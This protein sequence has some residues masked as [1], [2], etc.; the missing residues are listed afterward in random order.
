MSYG[1]GAHYIFYYLFEPQGFLASF[2][3]KVFG[4]NQDFSK[5]HPDPGQLVA[6]SLYVFLS[7]KTFLQEN[8]CLAEMG[9]MKHTF[10]KLILRRVAVLASW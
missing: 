4:R 1:T 2:C 7:H 3:E 9:I 5:V 8:V 10:T 6:L